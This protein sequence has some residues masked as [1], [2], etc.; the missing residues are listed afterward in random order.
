MDYFF[1]ENGKHYIVVDSKPLEV[2][3]SFYEIYKYMEYK[4]NYSDRK[5]NKWNGQNCI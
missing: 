2:S 3:K 4:N 1:E 5:Y